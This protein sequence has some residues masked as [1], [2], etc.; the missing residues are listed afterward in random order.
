MIC[1]E[2][3][4]KH[5]NFLYHLKGFLHQPDNPVFLRYDFD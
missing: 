5:I 3:I 2:T 1:K 4:L